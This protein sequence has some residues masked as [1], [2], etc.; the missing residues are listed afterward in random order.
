MINISLK[1]RKKTETPFT[2]F[3]KRGLRKYNEIRKRLYSI[4]QVPPL[5]SISSTV[6]MLECSFS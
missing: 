5:L 6:L 1:S 4:V 2:D 3:R